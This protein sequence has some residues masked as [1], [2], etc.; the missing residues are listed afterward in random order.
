MAHTSGVYIVLCNW[1]ALQVFDVTSC[2]CWEWMW[3]TY[4]WSTK[5]VISFMGI[6]LRTY[7]WGIKEM[8]PSEFPS[9]AV[10]SC[11]KLKQKINLQ[12]LPTGLFPFIQTEIKNIHFVWKWKID[13][14]I[15]DGY[16]MSSDWNCGWYNICILWYDRILWTI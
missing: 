8:L 7:I 16:D 11:N 15:G 3:N 13:A 6:Y 12:K 14:F 4:S 2:T 10:R 5:S 1:S 9:T